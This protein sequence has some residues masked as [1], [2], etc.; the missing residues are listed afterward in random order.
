V[1]DAAREAFSDG[2][3]YS[4]FAAAGFL[5]LGFLATLRLSG[6]AP[7]HEQREEEATGASV[8]AAR[9]SGEPV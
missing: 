6:T 9:T 4:A 3:R 1:A 8:T 7:H 2:T 5:V